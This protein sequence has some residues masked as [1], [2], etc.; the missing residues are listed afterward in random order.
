MSRAALAVGVLAA[1]SGCGGSGE[2]DTAPVRGTVTCEGTPVT[3][4]TITFS[5]IAE[6]A[7]DKPGKPAMGKIGSDGTFVLTTYKQGDGAII[8]MH[9]VFYA[10]AIAGE[11]DE[12]EDGSGDAK[13]AA[14]AKRPTAGKGKLL[15]CQL[16]GTAKIGVVNGKNDL[17][18]ELMSWFPKQDADEDDLRGE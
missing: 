4:G 8:G 9:E 6:D 15:P 16:G 1:V 5:P 12:D 18:I 13:P 14:P 2:F 11:G 3:S 7:V 17:K 10:P